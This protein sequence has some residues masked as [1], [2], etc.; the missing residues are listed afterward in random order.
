ME[1]GEDVHTLVGA[2]V[3]DAV[4]GPD[5]IRFEEHLADCASCREEIRE[6][7]EATARLAVAA[8]VV[9]RAELKAMALRAAEHTRQLPPVTGEAAAP[10][11]GGAVDPAAAGSRARRPLRRLV[12]RIAA[13][14]AAALIVL[15]FVLVT[16]MHSAQHQLDQAQ[17]RT[18]AI[19]A[20][21]NA[22]DA[23][24]LTSHVSTG[25]SATVVMS[26]AQHR[27]VFTAAGLHALPSAERYEL[28]LMSPAGAQPAGLFVAS[29]QGLASPMVVSGLA[30]GDWIGMTVEP[31][32]GSHQPTSA[33]VLML[34]LGSR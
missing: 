2:Y 21:L 23:V 4:S 27:L 32:S 20:V 9:P 29:R 24:M 25:G 6:L 1:P 19:A 17:L 30:R 26:H 31:A 3:M 11:V 10:S 16:V 14:A 33:P 5:R 12:P 13:V 15:V 28:W 7:R 8:A 22:P 18:R 34:N